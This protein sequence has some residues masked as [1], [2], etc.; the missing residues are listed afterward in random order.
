[1]FMSTESGLSHNG[2]KKLSTI[3]RHRMI[4]LASHRTQ[5]RDSLRSSLFHRA[6]AKLFDQLRVEHG[7]PVKRAV[8]FQM[9]EFVFS[10]DRDSEQE[11]N[12]SHRNPSNKTGVLRFMLTI[13][14]LSQL[15][16][17]EPKALSMPKSRLVLV[18]DRWKVKIT[19]VISLWSELCKPVRTRRMKIAAQVTPLR[20]VKKVGLALR[21]AA[22]KALAIQA[23]KGK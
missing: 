21:K 1:M 8:Q 20:Q 5:S 14:F 6:K 16:Q 10:L 18:T 2:E 22:Q 17:M 4:T 19:S 13:S 9:I 23:V 15:H 11:K 3:W 7:E 12:F